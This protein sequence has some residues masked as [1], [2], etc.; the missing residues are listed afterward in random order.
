[1]LY[2]FI[3]PQ[4]PTSL[5]EIISESD[6]SSL[7]PTERKELFLGLKDITGIGEARLKAIPLF[8]NI[9]GN[10]K[11]LGDMINLREETPEWLSAYVL[12]KED[13]FD[14]TQTYLIR[15]ENEFKE[16]IQKHF[17][18]F[19][20]SLN[21]LYNI[22]KNEW[23]SQFTKSLMDTHEAKDVLPIVEESD[24]TTKVYFLNRL[25]RIDLLSNS[26]Y[27]VDS[28]EFRVLQMAVSFL[29]EP[30][31]FSRKVFYDDK[32]LSEFTVSD[33]VICEWEQEGE[34]KRIKLSLAKIL[35]QYQNV[36][37]AI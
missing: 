32:Q 13:V 36:S 1:M 11:P 30:S 25:K 12:N 10:F 20:V 26:N 8:R 9:K 24:S 14:E 4:D 16:I 21:E 35:P 28:Y 3:S 2:N 17:S 6:F 27:K 29:D 23:T 15:S 5:F 37:D 18:E 31:S 34:K 7:D 22:Y 33:D 19:N